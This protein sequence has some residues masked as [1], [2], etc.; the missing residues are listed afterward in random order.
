MLRAFKRRNYRLWAAADFLSVAGAWMQ[1]LGVNWLLLSISGSATSLGLGLFLQSA[2]TLLLAMFGGSLADRLPARPLVITGQVFHGL[3]AA[4]L[5]VIAFNGPDHTGPIYLISALGGVV[6]AFCAPAIGRFAAE[7]VER[8]DL[9]NALGLGSVI[10]S[11][12]RIL[13]MGVAGALIPLIGTAA[14]FAANA[15]SFTGVIAAVLLMRTGEMRIM[16]RATRE[17]SKITDGLRYMLR[18]P[19]LLVVFG[20]AFALGSLG[21]NYQLTMAAMSQ[22]P[23]GA[24]AGGYGLLSVVFAVGAIIGGLVA[25]SRPRL[26]F[27]VLLVAGASISVFQAL[28]GLAPGLPLFAALMLL[29][30]V[31]AVV[32]DTTVAARIQLGT[33]E[34]MRGRV[35]AAQ[36]MVG[37]AAGATGGPL[38]G[39]LCDTAGP[40]AALVLAGVVTTAATLTAAVLLVRILGVRFPVLMPYRPAALVQSH[41]S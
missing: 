31:G 15:L 10:S 17:E 2:P 4:A 40:R 11:A 28:S 21:R 25:A 6:S 14:L 36:S 18:T 27:R 39:V 12:A 9:S 30:A 24:G 19:W 8:E 35:L 33:R 3:L 7:M 1:V 5:A 20:L 16:P 37:A 38:L 34:D 13:G 41:A 32:V 29:I 26:G 22:G 23:L